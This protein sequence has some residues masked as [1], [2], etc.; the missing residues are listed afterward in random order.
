MTKQRGLNL[1]AKR[2][3]KCYIKFVNNE[4]INEYCIHKI[5]SGAFSI[6]TYGSSLYYCQPSYMLFSYHVVTIRYC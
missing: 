6:T 5:D 2:R 3:K 4:V 1:Q